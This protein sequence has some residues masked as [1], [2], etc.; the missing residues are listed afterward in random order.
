M[1]IG[2]V[3]MLAACEDVIDIDLN[4]A[5]PRVV[6]EAEI[7]N[8]GNQQEIR[9]SRTVSFTDEI[10]YAPVSGAEVVVS[11][12]RGREV[13]FVETTP[14]VY[15]TDRLRGTPGMTYQLDVAVDGM[16][17]AAT[18]TMAN[19]VAIDSVSSSSGDF[20]GVSRRALHVH[21]QDP[22][23]TRDFFRYRMSV[24]DAPFF[25][26]I[27]F[28]DKFNNG[29]YVTHDLISLDVEL[30]TGDEVVVLRNQID[31]RVYR[32]WSGIAMLNPGAAAPSNPPSNISGG[33]LG[34]FSAQTVVM[35]RMTIAEDPDDE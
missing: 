21:F 15:V 2:C 27:V 33:A 17:Y 29:R 24:N 10:S 13:A 14:G 35:L 18:S 9:V 31:E 3:A 6:I 11:D 30:Q 7:N 25:N 26:L 1:L 22:P 32:Y 16:T 4:D 5:D 19:V 34:Y 28:N 20:F 23:D 12:E 8:L